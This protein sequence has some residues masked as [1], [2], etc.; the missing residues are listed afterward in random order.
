MY[1]KKLEYQK[2]LDAIKK[3]SW[4][5]YW[6]P[7]EFKTKDVHQINKIIKFIKSKPSV[8]AQCYCGSGKKFKNCHGV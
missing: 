1:G 5:L 7:E 6:V 3:H 8:N 2:H 4:N